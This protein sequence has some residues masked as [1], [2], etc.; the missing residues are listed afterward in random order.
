MIHVLGCIFEQ[1]DLR[2]V[3]LAAGLSFLACATALTMIARARAT[4]RI[5][6]RL[7]WLG[8]AGAVAG[9]GIWATH[10]V[11]MLAYQ[12]G[13]PVGFSAPLTILSA[14]I[15]MAL[16]G[17][18]FTLTIQR[19]GAVLGGVLTGLAI[20]AMHYTG[21]AAVE[22]PARAVWNQDYVAASLLIGVSLSALSMHVAMG[23]T[24]HHTGLA[25][26]LFSLAIL[27]M[28]FTGMSAVVFVP[29]SRLVMPPH[30][31]DA[32][33]L[34]IVVAAAS[35]FI[36]GQGLIV[37]LVDRYLDGQ[38]QGEAARMRGHI[39]ELEATQ[40]KLKTASR[41]LTAALN[42]AA[43]ANQAK[44]A[45]LAS[46]SHELR[47]P[48]N[49]II[50]FSDTMVMGIFGPLT[51]RYKGYAGDIRHSG[52]HLLAL[53]NDVLDL[54]RLDAGEGELRE[55][56]FD[57]AELVAECLRMM[58]GQAEKAQVAL[59]AEVA[60]ALPA[61]HADKRRIKQILINLISNALKFTPEGG[62]VRV[63]CR[64]TPQGLLLAVTDS[65]IGIAAADIPKVLE[66][67]GQVDSP[68]Q[69]KHNGTGLGL[70]LSRQLAQLHGGDLTLESVVTKGTT[71][72]V[73]LPPSRLVPAAAVAAA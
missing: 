50:G 8:G 66:R 4:G 62:R 32:F 3:A 45:F 27:G 11:A 73:T 68:A 70:P 57:T 65:G 54:S 34:A 48:L 67:F 18:G 47:T 28:H 31:V 39:T 40:Q 49:A 53:I 26:T 51:D 5:R 30:I 38:A 37:A 19:G 43:E 16:C 69:R 64:L 20:T 7:V 55:E 2:L 9:C 60:P 72:T 10:F 21:M 12:S 14:I 33:T 25:V 29:D 41:D 36:V 15:A 23:R 13:L 42:V 58:V 24:R 46:M 1:H 22:L 59:T 52:E 6:T 71:V 61:L 44:S 56:D 63:D 35:A 17:V